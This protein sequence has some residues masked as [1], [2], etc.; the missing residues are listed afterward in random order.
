MTEKTPLQREQGCFNLKPN[1]GR[2][3]RLGDWEV[4]REEGKCDGKKVGWGVS[5]DLL[6]SLNRE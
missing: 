6:L 2:R 3:G 5:P 1:V 4:G